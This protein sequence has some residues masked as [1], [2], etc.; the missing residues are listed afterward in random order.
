MI[1]IAYS[2]SRFIQLALILLFTLQFIWPAFSIFLFCIFFLSSLKFNKPTQHSCNSCWNNKENLNIF[3]NAL[4]MLRFTAQNKP[5]K[6]KRKQWDP[7][8]KSAIIFMTTPTVSFQIL[9]SSLS[10]LLLHDLH[11]SFLAPFTRKSH[12][13][14]QP[15]RWNLDS[16]FLLALFLQEWEGAGG[17][18][19]WWECNWL[20]K[21]TVLL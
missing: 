2:K 13:R 10:S 21:Q 9:C 5:P 1:D 12:L 20:K 18:C 19:V 16:L 15:V 6:T 3:Q 14:M 11:F 17:G 4:K 7:N 8:H